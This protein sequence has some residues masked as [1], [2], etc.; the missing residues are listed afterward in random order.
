MCLDQLGSTTL[1]WDPAACQQPLATDPGT[2]DHAAL[3]TVRKVSG[4][5]CCS[6]VDAMMVVRMVERPLCFQLHKPHA[7]G[8]RSRL[9]SAAPCRHHSV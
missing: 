1:T 2:E 4:L 9:I 6:F 8:C 3:I 7:H 5:P